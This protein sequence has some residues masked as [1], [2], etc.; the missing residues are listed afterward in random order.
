M[1][2]V[3]KLNYVVGNAYTKHE[4]RKSGILESAWR[5]P[6]CVFEQTTASIFS[7]NLTEHW[8]H[9]GTGFW[10]PAIALCS[11]GAKSRLSKAGPSENLRWHSLRASL[12]S[13]CSARL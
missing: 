9:R 13:G 8:P 10:G 1:I 11:V 7:V 4:F 2:K 5:V 6:F 12:G 3:D